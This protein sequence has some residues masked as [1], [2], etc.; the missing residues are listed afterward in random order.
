MSNLT[1][2][3]ALAGNVKMSARSPVQDERGSKSNVSRVR[4]VR[5]PARDPQQDSPMMDAPMTCAT[6]IRH[7]TSVDEEDEQNEDSIP[8]F[9][10]TIPAIFVPLKEDLLAPVEPAKDRA[11][12]L[13]RM[14]K[15]LDANEVAV[16]DNLAWMV[17]CAAPS[18]L[19]ELS[20]SDTSYQFEREAR[21]VVADAKKTH[22]FSQPRKPEPI[23]WAEADQ[24]IAS[25]STKPV[26]GESYHVR[27]ERLALWNTRL[28]M[29]LP[30]TLPPQEEAARGVLVVANNGS[31][32]IEDYSV[33]HIQRIRDRLNS[34]LGGADEA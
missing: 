20:R 27:P 8:V 22:D 11:E 33:Q 24:L 14:Q 30:G 26:N 25:T 34:S 28:S 15:S 19:R 29:P 21:R 16:R 5:V 10:H 4:N 31:R 12:R 23:S 7:R 3:M 18:T 2:N 32:D 9:A 6:P 13:Q 17:N 1:L